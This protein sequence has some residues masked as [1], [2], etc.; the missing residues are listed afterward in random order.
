MDLHAHSPTRGKGKSYYPIAIRDVPD[1]FR[2]NTPAFEG[3]F[4]A[5]GCLLAVPEPEPEAQATSRLVGGKKN[6]QPFAFVCYF[7]PEWSC[8]GN[9]LGPENSFAG[10]RPI[11]C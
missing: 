10:D 1:F 8:H 11:L 7:F 4:P 5:D 9:D 6:P 3:R 2:G